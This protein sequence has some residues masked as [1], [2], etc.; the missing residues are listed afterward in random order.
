[1]GFRMVLPAQG[2]D[3][4]RIGSLLGVQPDGVQHWGVAVVRRLM[5]D[6]ANRVHVGTEMLAN[7]IAGVAISQSGG[8]GGGFE[9]GQP[10]LW[11]EAR[12][13]EA[14]GETQLLMMKADTFSANRS[15]QIRL[16]EKNYLLIPNKLLE[17]GLDYDLASFRRIE[18]ESGSEGKVKDG[19]Q[20][21]RN[22]ATGDTS[23]KEEVR[24]PQKIKVMG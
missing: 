14:S 16:N 13:G 10:A 7:Q 11:L 21:T 9:D 6:E 18:Q 22:Q 8:G 3:N 24:R 23:G 15:L 20:E 4:I 19:A 2:T 5:R 1:S 12:Q 17:K